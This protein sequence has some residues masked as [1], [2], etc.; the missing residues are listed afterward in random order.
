VDVRGGAPGTR[1]TDLLD[2]DRLVGGVDAIVLSGGSV[3]GLA[4]AEGVVTALAAQGRGYAVAP[5]LPLAPIVPAAILFDLAGAGDKAWGLD[6]PYRRLGQ[7]ALAAASADVALGAEGAGY[8]AQAGA[9]QGGVGAASLLGDE[10]ITVGALA[11]VNA[12]GSAVMPGSHAFWAWPFEI[13]GEFGG[14]RPDPTRPNPDPDDWGLVRGR[15]APRT[16]TTLAVVATDAALTSAQARR[17]AVMAQD[18]LARA[19]RPIHTLFDGDVVFALSTGAR[20]LPEPWA[21]TLSLI[22]ERAATTLARAV[23]RGVYAAV[24]RPGGPAAYRDVSGR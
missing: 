17:L 22:G 9:L 16:A 21:Q 18:G 24:S 15:P 8:A 23:A 14:A 10:G 13:E 2:A 11:A 4:A 19:L 5:G 7:A 12:I 3:H 6:P 20:P 1:E